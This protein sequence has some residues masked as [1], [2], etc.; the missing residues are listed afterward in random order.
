MPRHCPASS[1][2]STTCK[3]RKYLD[4]RERFYDEAD[5]QRL[6]PALDW[7]WDGDGRNRNALLTVFR[8]FDN[9]TVV[10]GLRRRDS[11]DRVDHG[12][13]DLRADLLRPRRG[14]RRL[15]QRRR[16]SWRRGSTW[17][18]CACSR[19]TCSSSF[20]PA[21]R[22]EPIRASWYVGATRQMD[23]F[24]ADRLHG[25]DHGTQV[26]FRGKDVKARAAR[27]GPRAIRRPWRGRRI[28]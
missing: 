7:V 5:P 8:N 28:R 10:Q 27:A 1:G 6:G 26:Q 14:L 4:E 21:D 15:R 12:L 23:Y 18:T 20:L 22:R 9:A 2:S 11:E 3:Q 24:L 16:T 19:R 13:P 25:M 17:T